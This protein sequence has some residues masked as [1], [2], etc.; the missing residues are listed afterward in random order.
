MGIRGNRRSKVPMRLSWVL[1]LESFESWSWGVVTLVFESELELADS[2][3]SNNMR[4]AKP[5]GMHMMHILYALCRSF[6]SCVFFCHRC[7][8]ELIRL[9]WETIVQDQLQHSEKFEQDYECS[10]NWIPDVRSYFLGF[11][12]LLLGADFC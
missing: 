5:R 1:L 9:D 10:R 4:E 11:L 2:P 6:Q 12:S 8:L 3:F 7:C